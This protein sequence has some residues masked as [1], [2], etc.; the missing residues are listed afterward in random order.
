M[1]NEN[2]ILTYGMQVL[3]PLAVTRRLLTETAGEDIFKG[4]AENGF[5]AEHV[6]LMTAT[7][8]TPH[9]GKSGHT[10]FPYNTDQQF[11]QA[12]KILML[13]SWSTVLLEKLEVFS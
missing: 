4:P 1:R 5:N 13:T 6:K 12:P 9:G 2:G 8:P 11:N 10:I 3:L 7:R